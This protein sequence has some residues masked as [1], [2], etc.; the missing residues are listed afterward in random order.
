MLKNFVVFFCFILAGCATKRAVPMMPVPADGTRE[1]AL[2]DF[3]P[4]GSPCLDGIVVNLLNVGCTAVGTVQRPEYMSM[5]LGCHNPQPG[6]TDMFSRATFIYS[7]NPMIGDPLFES[8]MPYC[9]DQTG[10]YAVLDAS[11]RELGGN[12]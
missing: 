10:V 3:T 8:A 12:E 7:G 4:S 6:A 9:G 11:I 1:A 5:A 2:L